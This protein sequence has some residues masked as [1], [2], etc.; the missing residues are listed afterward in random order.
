MT[1]DGR[2]VEN[3]DFETVNGMIESSR[4]AY[5]QETEKE[6]RIGACG[7][8]TSRIV[9]TILCSPPLAAAYLAAQSQ[10]MSLVTLEIKPYEADF[11][12]DSLLSRL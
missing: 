4:K 5:M 3:F 8:R 12:F 2:T 6:V 11:D 1:F 10:P 7:V 9:P